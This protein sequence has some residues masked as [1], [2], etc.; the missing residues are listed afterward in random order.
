MFALRTICVEEKRRYDILLIQTAPFTFNET[1]T[2]GL[3]LVYTI[4]YNIILYYS[5][6]NE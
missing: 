5:M 4:L 6:V 2:I 3:C 1:H